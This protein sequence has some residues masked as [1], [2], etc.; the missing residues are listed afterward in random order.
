MLGLGFFKRLCHVLVV[1]G[2]SHSMKTVLNP[3]HTACLLV[4]LSFLMHIRGIET[5]DMEWV[6][7]FFNV[8]ELRHKF[9]V[10]ERFD[11]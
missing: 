1:H 2:R 8:N 11:S 3:F 7:M 5:S 10:Q 4:Y 9:T 6:K